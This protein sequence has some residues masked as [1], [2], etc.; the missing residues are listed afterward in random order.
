MLLAVVA[1]AFVI[2]SIV[3]GC[4]S[5]IIDVMSLRSQEEAVKRRTLREVEPLILD[6]VKGPK[7]SVAGALEATV[8]EFLHEEPYTQAELE[9]LFGEGLEA[10]FAGNASQ[11][12]VLHV[13]ATLG[14]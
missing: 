4:S 9:T 2:V 11:L 8:A 5:L 12:R 3:V 1:V 14:E 10:F 13:A 6:R 7:G